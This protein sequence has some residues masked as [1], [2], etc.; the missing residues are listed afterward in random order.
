MSEIRTKT[1]TGLKKDDTFSV[2]RTFSEADMKVFAEIS[3]DYNPVHFDERFAAVKNFD[4]CICHGMLVASLL[5]EIGGQIGWLASGMDLRFLK[6]VYFG[7]SVTCVCTIT[8]V[9]ERGK[10][11]AGCL[12]TNQD[13]ETV[14][15][16]TLKGF[17]PGAKE[18][19]VLK[20]M[21]GEGDPTNPLS[22]YEL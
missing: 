2:T 15:E 1:I 5:T 3:R 8:E 18:I 6:P 22:D 9:N 16:A 11:E 19:A 21:V 17:I 10:A 20:K 14:L 13:G 4:R 7:D 12:F